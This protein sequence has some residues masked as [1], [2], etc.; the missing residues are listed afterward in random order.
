MLQT[1]PLLALRD[2]VDGNGLPVQAGLKHLGSVGRV[3]AREVRLGA[4]QRAVVV[5]TAHG[6]LQH[7]HE[8]KG[9]FI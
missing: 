2:S 5:G 8:T 9:T 3:Q 6:D 7:R 1:Y 4:H